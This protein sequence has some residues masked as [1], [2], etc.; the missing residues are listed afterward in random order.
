LKVRIDQYRFNGLSPVPAGY[1]KVTSII[2][3]TWFILSYPF[4]IFS[5]GGEP[6]GSHSVSISTFKLKN[7][8]LTKN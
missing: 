1:S 4:V 6:P 7:K 3:P 2:R 8:I 5:F